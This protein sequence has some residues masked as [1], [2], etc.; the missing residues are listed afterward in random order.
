MIALITGTNSGIGLATSVELAKAGH[1]VVATMRNPSKADALNAAADAAGVSVQVAALDVTDP[2]AITTVVAD[3]VA[4]HGSI[5]V[6]IN[7][8]GATYVG[9]LEQISDEKLAWTMDVNFTGVAQL[10][11]EVMPHMRAQGGGR[12]VSVTS[13]GGA[14]GQPFNDAYCAAKFA[15]EGLMQSLHPVAAAHGIKVSVVQPGAV[16]TEFVNNAGDSVGER[17]NTVDAYS[18]QVQNYVERTA[19]AF[20]NAQSPQE[21]AEVIAA[22]V[23]DP[24]PAFRYQTSERSTMFSGMSLSD[25]DGS[26]VT[27]ATAA[28]VN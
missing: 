5:D 13:V 24:E 20:D 2:A 3:V 26:T 4:E 16:A 9:T 19:G 23:A 21:V 14:V 22:V 1:T 6:L 17:M 27:G 7:N 15:V 11:R 18:Q 10:S 28:W 12:I 8:A 25:L